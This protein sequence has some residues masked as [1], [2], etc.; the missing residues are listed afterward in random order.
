MSTT[1][2]RLKLLG[3][4]ILPGIVFLIIDQYLKWLAVKFLGA[5]QIYFGKSLFGAT[6]ELHENPGS[7]LSLGAQFGESTRNVIFVVGVSIIL[8][9]IAIIWY[10][11]IEQR[12][13]QSIMLF[14]VL[15][16]G[17][18]NLIDRIIN[19]GRVIDYIFLNFF[20]LNTGVFNLADVAITIGV[21][22][23]LLGPWISKRAS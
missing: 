18:G 4:W 17:T 5:Q 20:S 3:I 16:G 12:R 10:R 13:P 7:F 19:S 15:L 22:G 6:L 9:V 14:L 8:M 11:G 23:L 2:N 21:T 1:W